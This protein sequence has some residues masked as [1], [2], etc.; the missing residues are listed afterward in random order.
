MATISSGSPAQS[1]VTVALIV[2]GGLAAAWGWIMLANELAAKIEVASIAGAN[3]LFFAML[4]VP[5]A[6]LALLLGRMARVKV[7]RAGQD[8]SRW[9]TVGFA[10]G[11]GGLGLSVAYSWLN[12]GLVLGENQP[13]STPLI[14]LGLMLTALQVGTEELL[15]R[16]WLQPVLVGRIGPI[17]G[18]VLGA[19]FFAAFHTVSGVRAPISFVTLALGGLLFGLLALRSGGLLAPFGAHYAWNVIEDIG[20]GLVPN[21]GSGPMGSLTDLDLMGPSFWGGHEEGLNAS[22]GTVVVLI[23]LILPLLRASPVSQPSAAD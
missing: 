10:I 19:L 9:L 7:L 14:V 3:V 16:G 22:I 1:S 13:F 18:I 12:G 15:F 6:L 11:S 23:A 2:V 20:L 17:S 5:L 21:P 4:F 8:R